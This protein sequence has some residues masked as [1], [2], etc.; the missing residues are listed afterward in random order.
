MA[1]QTPHDLNLY[2]VVG[3]KEMKSIDVEYQVQ[4]GYWATR[5]HLQ[6]Y[7]IYVTMICM[8][9][10]DFLNSLLQPLEDNPWLTHPTNWKYKT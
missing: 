2:H 4:V 1:Y 3:N 7:K 10:E 8:F 6:V 5:N 9:D